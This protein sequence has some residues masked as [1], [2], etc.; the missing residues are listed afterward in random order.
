MLTIFETP[1]FVDEAAKVWS[2]EDRLASSPGSPVSQT[3][4]SSSL[5]ALDAEKFAGLVPAQESKAV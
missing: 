5:A 3:L 2:D 4:A 1:T